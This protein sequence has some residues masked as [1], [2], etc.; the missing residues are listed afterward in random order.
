MRRWVWSAMKPPERR[1]RLRE[2]AEWVDW[3]RTTF[4]LHN[5]IPRCWYMHQPVVEH[6]TALYAG[7]LRVYAGA[8][9]AGM[10]EA[11]WISTLHAFTPRL[12]LA[13]C[14]T[15]I[16]QDPPPVVPPPPG[17]LEDFELHL[18]T[19]GMATAAARHPAQAELDRLA[20]EADPPL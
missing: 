11:D 7:W 19:S 16:H 10:G 14:A 15:G 2:L 13:A 17:T 20:A 12:Q 1:A 3:L 9:P 18:A 6:L 5:Q 8:P 4:E